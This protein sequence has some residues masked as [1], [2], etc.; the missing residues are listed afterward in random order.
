MRRTLRQIRAILTE[1]AAPAAAQALS[2]RARAGVYLGRLGLQILKQWARDRCPQQ[3]SALA[4]ETALSLVPMLAIAVTVL[5]AAGLLDAESRLFE[6]LARD[7]LP[8]LPDVARPLRDFAAKISTGAAG[9]AA[10]GFTFVTAFALYLSMGKVF[11]DIWRVK[12][13][14]HLLYR[15]L[16]FSVLV[17]VLPLLA[18]LYLYWSA[19]GLSS[20]PASRFLTPLPI[21]FLALLLTNKL[22]PNTAVKWRA[23]LAGTVVSGVL[24]EALKWGFVTLARPMMLKNYTGIY[25]SVGLIPVVLVWIYASWLIVLLGVEIAAAVQNLTGTTGERSGPKAGRLGGLS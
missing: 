10:L 14:R 22:L 2:R 7:V 5:R 16:V 17:T 15:L 11:N 3:A 23:A 9:P 4:F 1:G 18:G 6:S 19:E 21:Q 25:G 12:V 8:D 20:G 24:L 13:Y